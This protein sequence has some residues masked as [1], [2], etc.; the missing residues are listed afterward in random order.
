MKKHTNQK[1]HIPNPILWCITII[2]L[3]IIEIFLLIAISKIPRSAIKNNTRESAQ[4]FMQRDVF[5]NISESDTASRID[6]YADAIL[7]NILYNYDNNAPLSSTLK[8]A[9][10]HSDN[11]NEND[12]LLTAV[13]ANTAP[14]YEYSRYW[15]GSAI[16]IRPLLTIFNIKQIYILFALLLIALNIVVSISLYR[17]GYKACMIS[18][19]IALIAISP[20]YIPMSL[21]YIWCFLIMLISV[22]IMMYLHNQYN[23]VSPIFFLIIG[24]VTAYFDFLTTETL[25]LLAPLSILI[26]IMY[27]NNKLKNFKE[28][29]KVIISRSLAWGIGYISSWIIKWTI[30]SVVL[31]KDVFSEALSSA[32]SRIYGNADNLT[33]IKLS[34]HALIRNI[35][36]ILPFNFIPKYSYVYAILSFL[37]I[38]MIYY[39]FRKN[40]NKNFITGLFAI[41]YCI[42]YIRYITLANHSYI[43]YFF[44]YRAQFASVFCLCIIFYYG[45]D[46]RLVSKVLPFISGSHN[47]SR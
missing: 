5:Y 13:S 21:E 41:I 25:T 28:G 38:L 18:F 32:S 46:R 17:N 20:W 19:L 6:H 44:T 34:V 26:I 39:L 23:M 14:T 31:H 22:L 30:S 42:P 35:S 4:Y 45:I 24:D 29:I 10:Y 7:I 27:E 43:H 3:T 12:N 47:P 33:G 37:V 36:C 40:K 16:L 8:A 11:Y 2:I 9:Y 1:L 15:H